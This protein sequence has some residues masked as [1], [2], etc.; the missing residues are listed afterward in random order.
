VQ[1]FTLIARV[2]ER[3]YERDHSHEGVHTE[4]AYTQGERAPFAPPQ[5]ERGRSCAFSGA[6]VPQRGA[7]EC[8]EGTHAIKIS[9]HTPLVRLSGGPVSPVQSADS[10]RAAV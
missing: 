3:V 7:S 5:A 10:H 8:I 2:R 6:L 1:Q 4:R 9:R